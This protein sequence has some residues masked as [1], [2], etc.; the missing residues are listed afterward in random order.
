MQYPK[1]VKAKAIGYEK[2]IIHFD[3]NVVKELSLKPYLK[4]ARFH[5]LL[6]NP[7]MIKTFS[8]D[9]GYAISWNDE[10]DISEYDAWKKG[11]NISHSLRQKSTKKRPSKQ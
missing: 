5:L 7:S 3:N 6:A 8:I 11:K 10:A 9:G 1:I 2:L 4:T